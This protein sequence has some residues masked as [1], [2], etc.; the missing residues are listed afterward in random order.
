MLL[1]SI[2]FAGCT[3]VAWASPPAV[4]PLVHQVPA[5]IRSPE[6]ECSFV[7]E[8]ETRH[9]W[10]PKCAFPEED[11]TGCNADGKHME[12]RF[13]GEKDFPACPTC[14]FEH[15]PLTKYFWDKNC[16]AGE[17]TLGCN[18][19]GIHFE[20]RWCG[21]KEGEYVKCPEE[22][23]EAPA[24]PPATHVA[25]TTTAAAAA[26]EESE[27]EEKEEEEEEKEE[28]NAQPEE[29]P[30]QEGKVEEEVEE[31]VTSTKVAIG[32]SQAGRVDRSRPTVVV[33]DMEATTTTFLPVIEENAATA[34]AAAQ[35]SFG[36]AAGVILLLA[37]C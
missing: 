9:A 23:K 13:C 22:E 6:D 18:A 34:A 36:V 25:P 20:C 16:K 29:V 12:C 1:R 26:A 8:P 3:F 4:A 31:E 27:V 5:K 21:D 19:D 11:T 7:V 24:S 2:G 28:E 37:R 15:Q 10:D 35:I 32:T 14:D 17:T 30:K 33:K